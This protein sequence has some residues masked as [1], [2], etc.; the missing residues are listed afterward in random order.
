MAD[1]LWD[2]LGAWA[3][4]HVPSLIRVVMIPV[5]AY[6][7]TRIVSA[8]SHRLERLAEDDDPT[9]VSER[10][11]RARTLGRIV[12]QTTAFL[13][14]SVAIML[15]LSE[16]G[17]NLGPILA[18]A[19]IVGLAV[20]FGAQTLVK[21]LIAGF[22]LLLE[23]QVRVQ[24]FISVGDVSGLVESM[25]LRTTVLRDV[26]GRVHIIPNGAIS[27]VTNHTR[28]WSR[29]VLDVGVSYKEDTDRCY[30]VLREVGADLERDP[31]FGPKLTERFE[32]PGVE[33][34]GEAS[35]ILRMMVR[36]KPLEQWTVLRELRRRVKHAFEQRGIEIPFPSMRLVADAAAPSRT[37]ATEK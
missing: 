37:T 18:G 7:L 32:Y 15:V 20:G 35:V 14:W 36:T 24:D 11:K 6:V 34:L 33:R 13:V 4:T 29:A 26:E 5:G 9:T 19:G 16:L 2:K 22:F 8:L 21:D 27:V 17:V 25:T 1:G 10:E 30:E 3:G 12:R 23:D 28:G 31:V